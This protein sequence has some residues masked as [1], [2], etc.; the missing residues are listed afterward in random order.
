MLQLPR[1]AP[2]SPPA[3]P[4]W[5]VSAS[6]T[7]DGHRLAD[8]PALNRRVNAHPGRGT[9]D[10]AAADSGGLSAFRRARTLGRTPPNFGGLREKSLPTVKCKPDTTL[11]RSLVSSRTSWV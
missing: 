8:A 6:Y 2:Q 3:A 10:Q 7:C 5:N 1:P 4:R 9:G 11:L